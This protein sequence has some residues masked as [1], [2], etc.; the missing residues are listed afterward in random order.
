MEKRAQ[1]DKTIIPPFKRKKKC[2]PAYS[3]C[4]QI[5]FDSKGMLFKKASSKFLP[6]WSVCLQEGSNQFSLLSVLENTVHFLY[7]LEHCVLNIIIILS[8]LMVK[9]PPLAKKREKL[10]HIQQLAK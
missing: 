5:L 3:R 2:I 4:R 1:H 8:L 6:W 10:E 9:L 7:H